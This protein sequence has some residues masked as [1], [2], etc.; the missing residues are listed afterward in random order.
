MVGAVARSLSVPPVTY[1]AR[2]V[3]R[4]LRSGLP[5]AER[6][7]FLRVGPSAV[8]ITKSASS[9]QRVGDGVSSSRI[10]SAVL[11]LNGPF[12]PF[13]ASRYAATARRTTGFSSGVISITER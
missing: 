3:R 13:F 10:S 7:R 2:D 5:A 8:S 4:V 9:V 11:L 12:C 6:Y 1:G